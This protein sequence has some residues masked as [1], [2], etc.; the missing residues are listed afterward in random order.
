MSTVRL[1]SRSTVRPVA[2]ARRPWTSA[3]APAS[4]G[5][6][7]NGRTSRI[8]RPYRRAGLPNSATAAALK[9]VTRPLIEVVTIGVRRA[10]KISRRCASCDASARG[11]NT[12]WVWPEVGSSSARDASNASQSVLATNPA[13]GAGSSGTFGLPQPLTLCVIYGRAGR[14]DDKTRSGVRQGRPYWFF[15]KAIPYRESTGIP[16]APQPT[17]EIHLQVLTTVLRRRGAPLEEGY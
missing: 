11:L 10:A 7:A 5:S 6:G 9:P 16:I 14:S 13:T 15:A 4:R 1:T 8:L 3:A 2:S 12:V 17:R